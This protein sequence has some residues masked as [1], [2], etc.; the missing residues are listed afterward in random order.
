MWTSLRDRDRLISLLAEANG[1]LNRSNALTRI[2]EALAELIGEGTGLRDAF[3][4]KKVSDT[5]EEEHARSEVFTGAAYKFFL[6]IY[7]GLRTE[8]GD[9]VA[10]RKAG[11]IMGI[12]LTRAND[13]MPENQMTLEDVAKAYLKVDK[14]F[15]EY[16]YHAALV[17]E[18]TR[19]E[20]FDADSVTEWWAHEAATPQLWLHPQWPDYMVERLIQAS[21]DKLGIGPDFGLKLQSVTRINHIVRGMGLAQAIVRVQLMRGRG[22]SA[23]PLDNHGILVFRGS[24]MLADYHS[25]LPSGDSASLIADAFSQAQ[26]MSMIGQA[27]QLSIAQRGAPLA[28]ARRPDGQLMVEAR[29]MRGAGLKPYMEV[30]TLD[31][32]LGERREIVI[33]TLPP[34]KRIRISDDLIK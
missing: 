13:Y 7:G 27:Y 30:F 6:K 25:P 33:P 3:H 4:D 29:I 24:G 26:A 31:N 20:I 23:T 2:G 18:F 1:D 16:R 19:R 17:D 11:E 32:P 15:F 9:E 22:D 12:F 8:L 28:I 34:D 5:S 10:L 14:E 21:I